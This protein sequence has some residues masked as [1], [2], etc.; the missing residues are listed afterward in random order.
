MLNNTKDIIFIE[1]KP[2]MTSI[3]LSIVQL[4]PMITIKTRKL[5]MG[6]VMDAVKIILLKTNSISIPEDIK[7]GKESF[8]LVYDR[9]SDVSTIEISIKRIRV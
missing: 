4:L 2:F 3:I 1:K 5:G 9:N 6:H 8:V 7:I